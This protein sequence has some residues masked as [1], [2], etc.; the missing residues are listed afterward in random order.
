MRLVLVNH[1]H[2]DTPHICGRRFAAFAAALA[3]RGCQVVLLT[4]SLDPSDRGIAPDALRAELGSWDWRRPYLLACPPADFPLLR[5]AREDRL[6]PV[7]RK[8]VIAG[9]FLF[10]GGVFADWTR[11]SRAHWAAIGGIFAPDLVWATFGKTDAWVIAG[12]IAGIAECPWVADIKDSW[13]EMIPPALRAPLARRFADAAAITALSRGHAVD[14][15]TWF[16][17]P[18]TIVYSGVARARIWRDNAPVPSGTAFRITLTGSIY[19]PAGLG[20]LLR[21]ITAWRAHLADKDRAD[22]VFA[23]AGADSARAAAIADAAGA[24]EFSEIESYLSPDSFD[25]WIDRAAIN[26]HFKSASTPLHHKVFDLIAAARPII[27][28]PSETPEIREITAHAKARMDICADTGAAMTAIDA[29]W[30]ARAARGADIDREAF[31]AYSWEAQADI[32]LALFAE[33]AKAHIAGTST[34]GGGEIMATGNG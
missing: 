17:K 24:A 26:L 3:L 25:D 22:I 18:A 32:L 10:R 15:E 12:A 31:A 1:C 13:S 34:G 5:A 2:P 23:Y 6:T 30:R 20:A 8:T 27:C 16:E 4:Q 29:L 33:T 21:E 14:A 28:M 19:D 7:L 9:N 11:A